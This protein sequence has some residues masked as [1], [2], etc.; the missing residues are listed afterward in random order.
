LI[1]A[2]S[3]CRSLARLANLVGTA[4]VVSG[5]RFPSH[6]NKFE[7]GP[8]GTKRPDRERVFWVVGY[9]EKVALA[10]PAVG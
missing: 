8:H 3:R 9:F 7:D 1:T 2:I 4:L 5:S 10:Y 6:H